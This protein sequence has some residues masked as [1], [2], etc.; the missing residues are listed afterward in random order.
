MRSA[1]QSSRLRRIIASYAVNRLGT[2]FG[3]VALSVAVFDHTHSALAVATLLISG[4]VLPALLAPALVAR[5][6]VSPRA[7]ALSGLYFFETIATIALALLLWHFWLPAVLLLVALDGTAALSA[8]ALLRAAAARTSHEDAA[9][10]TRLDTEDETDLRHEAERKANA[11]L[12]IAFSGTFVLGPALAGAVVAAAGGSTALFIDAASFL[13]CGAMLADQRPHVEEPGE[14]VS[15]RARLRAAWRHI[16]SVRSLRTLLLTEALALVFFEFAGPIEIAYAKVTLHVG[17]S[18]Y[19]VLLASWGVGVVAGSIFFARSAH[20]R[21]GAML[22]A[23]TLAVGLAY[24]GFAAAASLVIACVAALCGGVGNGIQWASLISAVQRLTPQ[25]LHGRLMGA[26]ESLGSLCPAVGLSL[27]GVL[28][29]VSSPRGAFL[30]AGLGA[31][32]TSFV[33]ARLFMAGIT[34]PPGEGGAP[35]AADG[36]PEALISASEGHGLGE[37]VLG[38]GSSSAAQPA[39][40]TP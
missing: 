16:N 6:E 24:V 9:T 4:Q 12:N 7:G 32:A 1:F 29:A 33:F 35:S 13:I 11:A 2:W 5:I 14:G 10:I 23:S 28:V 3:F 31:I 19:G 15:V 38:H 30:V 39:G 37:A 21:V 27:G 25:R 34:S 17:D 18:G 36:G 26:I 8:S 22:S 40:K 20:R